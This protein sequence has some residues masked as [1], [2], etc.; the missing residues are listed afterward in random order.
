MRPQS[1]FPFFQKDT[2]TPTMRSDR[3]YTGTCTLS[4]PLRTSPAPSLPIIESPVHPQTPRNHSIH[5]LLSPSSHYVVTWTSVFALGQPP[6]PSPSHVY[7]TCTLPLFPLIPHLL[8]PFLR[9]YIASPTSSFALR[10]P[11]APSPS[12]YT[13]TCTLLESA[14]YILTSTS[15]Y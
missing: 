15:F 8:I 12:H 1:A 10:T 2:R 6:A 11:P 4:F 3:D 9:I 13:V 14:D 5:H 7:L